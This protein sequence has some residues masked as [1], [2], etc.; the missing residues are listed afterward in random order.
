MAGAVLFAEGTRAVA[1]RVDYYVHLPVK[2][3]GNGGERIVAD[4]VWAEGLSQAASINPN[5]SAIP[6]IPR[7]FP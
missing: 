2:Y 3:S 7:K 4:E 5:A 6:R 1:P